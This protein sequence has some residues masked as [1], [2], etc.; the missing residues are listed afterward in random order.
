MLVLNVIQYKNLQSHLKMIIVF[1][2][3]RV[4]KVVFQVLYVLVFI[5]V[6]SILYIF[7]PFFFILYIYKTPL[8]WY[9]FWS[10]FLSFIKPTILP[11]LSII[12]YSV[13][14]IHTSYLKSART[15]I[16]CQAELV[17]LGHF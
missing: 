5:P 14:P 4:C 16:N 2:Y 7:C 9:L 6:I 10:I 3:M 8:F 13:N 17:K 11:I 15:S 1:I 12:P